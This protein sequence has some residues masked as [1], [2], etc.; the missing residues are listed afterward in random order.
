MPSYKK[1]SSEIIH[2]NAW[3][4]YFHDEYLLPD[5]KTGHYYFGEVNE[6]GSVM[7]IPLL[8][9][10]HL[11]L[12]VQQ[13]YL[14]GKQSVEFPG[15]GMKK[16]ETPSEAAGRELLE[17]TGHVAGDLMKVGSFDALN[18]VFK[19]TCHVFI[20]TE[21][22]KIGRPA[23]CPDELIDFMVRRV[24]EYEEMVRNGG[25]WDGQTLAAWALS[26]D[27]IYKLLNI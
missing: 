24:D 25:I 11:I 20:A 12:N 1:I 16:G 13:R 15:G 19:D 26:K 27:K 7:V 22:K 4:T 9:D 18:G 5:G 17:E 8:D 14:R 2:K 21:L 3:W 10:G 23:S 6:S